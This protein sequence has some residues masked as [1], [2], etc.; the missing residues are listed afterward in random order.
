MKQM[1]SST[2]SDATHR[3]V[4][5][6]EWIE[7]SRSLLKRE[8][9]LTRARDEVGRLRR[10]LPWVRVERSYVFDGP[11]GQRGLGELFG[12]KSQLLVY[13]FMFAPGWTEGCS[14]CS[15]VC[16]H[17]DAARQHFEHND[18]AFAAIS[19]APVADF[20]PFKE[21]MG[22]SFPWLSSNGNDFS[23]DMGASFRPEDLERGPVPYNFVEQKLRSEDQPG[24]TVFTKND[25]GHIYRT[26]SSYERGLEPLIGAYS[27]LDLAP[28]GRQ[29][30]SA[31]DWMKLHDRYGVQ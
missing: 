23:Y 13:H 2:A 10:E 16:D 8:K 4:T 28:K 18:L 1:I 6:E 26:Y 9:E 22:W 27:F 31:M 15:F 17:V 24:L 5:H 29:E 7:A 19:R 3:V 25:E 14:G 21:R 11:D 30:Q 20:T 12:G